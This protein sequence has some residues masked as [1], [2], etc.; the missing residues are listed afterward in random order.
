MRFVL[1]AEDR[2]VSYKGAGAIKREFQSWCAEV[3]VS[4]GKIFRRYVEGF[5]DEG[6]IRWFL[7]PHK[8]YEVSCFQGAKRRFFCFTEGESLTELTKKEAMHWEK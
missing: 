4:K 2:N 8:L 1:T 7:E 6:T 3:T 5:S